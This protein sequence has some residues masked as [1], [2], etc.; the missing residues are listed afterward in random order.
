MKKRILTL[1]CAL[2]LVSF[3]SVFAQYTEVI[4][5]N[6]P[7]FSESPYSVGTGIYQFESSIFFRNTSIEPTFSNPQ[8]LGLDLFFR[9]SFFFERLELNTQLTYQKDK[10]AFKNIFA[11]HYFS[12]GFSKMTVGAKYLVF[13]Q[14]YTDKTK[15]IRSWRKRNAFDLKRLIPSVAVYAG[16]NMDYLNRIHKTGGITPKAGVL[17][18]NDLSHDFN[19]VT[20]FFYDNIGSEFEEFSYIVTGTYNFSDRWSTFFESQ[21]VFQKLQTNSNIGTGLAFLY[22]PNLQ[23]NASVRGVFEGEA[24]GFYTGLGVS[25]RMNRH[26]DSYKEL[27]EN[28]NEITDRFVEYDEKENFFSRFLNIFKKKDKRK[29]TDTET[30]KRLKRTREKASKNK[31][32][33]KGGFFGLFGKKKGKKRKQETETEKLE[34]EIKELEKELKKDK[35]RERKKKKRKKK[36]KN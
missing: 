10:I 12:S 31:G 26:Q 20:N 17:L 18:Q 16:A 6:K 15:E 22:T 4:N 24:S 19:I 35:R 21:G 8:S 9:T 32:R 33:G 27:D 30:R 29:K 14:K 3:H 13:Q 34:R 5:S 28:G 7:G 2:F 25:Y 1:F 36:D 11:S 23:F